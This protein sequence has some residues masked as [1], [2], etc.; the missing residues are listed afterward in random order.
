MGTE[1]AILK[2]DGVCSSGLYCFILPLS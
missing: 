2:R 1:V